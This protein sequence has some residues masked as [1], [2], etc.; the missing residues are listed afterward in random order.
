MLA[1]KL[2]VPLGVSSVGGLILEGAR[3]QHL[4]MR[5]HARERCEEPHPRPTHLLALLQAL[6]LHKPAIM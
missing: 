1:L 2:L 4:C 5:R 3:L 6:L